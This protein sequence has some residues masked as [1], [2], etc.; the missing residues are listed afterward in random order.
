LVARAS[1]ARAVTARAGAAPRRRRSAEQ[2]T[3]PVNWRLLSG[4]LATVS[5]VGGTVAGLAVLVPSGTVGEPL[6]RYIVQAV[7]LTA[8]LLPAWPI[9]LGVLGLV[10]ALRPEPLVSSSRL[11]GAGAA[12]LALIGLFHVVLIGGPGSLARAEEGQGG[13]LI[14]FGLGAGLSDALGPTAAAILLVAALLLGILAA[15][16]VTLSRAARW[17]CIN[18]WRLGQL[19]LIGAGRVISALLERRQQRLRVNRPARPRGPLPGGISQLVKGPGR[20]ARVRASEADE[21]EPAQPTPPPRGSEVWQVPPLNLFEVGSVVEVS[22]VDIR[23]RAKTIEETLASFNI[24]AR[25]IEVNQGPTVTQFGIEPAPGVAVRRILALQNDLGLRMGAWPVRFE[26]PVPGKRV[27]G[28]EVPNQSVQVVAIR[29]LLESEAAGRV[30]SKLKLALGQDVSGRP[31]V[32]D[33]TRMPHLLIAGATGSGKSVC[34]NSILASLLSQ[35]TPDELQLLMIDPKMVELMPFSGIPH[36]RMPVVTDMDKVVGALKW[37]VREME[38]RYA[39][40]VQQA[41]RNIEGF[42]RAVE[43]QPG[44]RPLP[45]LVVVIDELADMM[46]T[47]PDEVEVSICRLAQKARATGIHLIVATQRPSVDVLTGMIKANFVTRIAFAVSSQVDSRVILDSVGAEKLLGRG[48]MLYNSGDVSK[49]QRIQGAWVSDQELQRLVT[50]WKRQGL[51]RFTQ[52]DVE[53][54]TSLSQSEEQDEA[55]EMYQKAVGLTEQFNRVSTSL[56]QRRLGIGYPRAARLMDLMEDRGVL[57]ASEDGKSR[58]V[59]RRADAPE[60]VVE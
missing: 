49:P 47:A 48:D 4:L 60:A 45:Y 5:L 16:D 2:A 23:A 17:L 34:I 31:V 35:S 58:E 51:P 36:L 46:M 6:R 41:A 30:R 44:Q 53:E 26:A 12:H 38:R 29:G 9:M 3:R 37:V 24:E 43:D 33:L 56:L 7:G 13:G 18:G 39:L 59:V 52:G 32:A 27:V 54:M 42:N 25:V 28:L 50:Y 11:W 21:V 1:S 22:Q 57:T 14:G 19:C 55:E 8:P 20:P 10:R 15:S 40:F